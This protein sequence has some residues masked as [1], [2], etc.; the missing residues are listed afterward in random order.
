MPKSV[1]GPSFRAVLVLPDPVFAHCQPRLRVSCY[2]GSNADQDDVTYAVLSS[3]LPRLFDSQEK[4]PDSMV[5]RKLV[6]AY[7]VASETG[8]PWPRDLVLAF[9]TFES[10]PKG[11]PKILGLRNSPNDEWWENRRCGF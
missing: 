7:Q 9:T 5:G 11:P 3:Q 6:V 4:R 8:R 10:H 2:R 1:M